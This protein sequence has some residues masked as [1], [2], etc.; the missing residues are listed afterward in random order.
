MCLYSLEWYARQ[1]C[2]V[3]TVSATILKYISFDRH[4]KEKNVSPTFVVYICN[5]V[6][7]WNML[8]V[9]KTFFKGV[10]IDVCPGTELL[11]HHH[12]Q[13]VFFFFFYFELPHLSLIYLR[14]TSLKMI[15]ESVEILLNYEKMQHQ[16]HRAFWKVIYKVRSL[17][18]NFFKANKFFFHKCKLCIV[19]K[20]FVAK[21]MSILQKYL[22][23]DYSKW[24]QIRM[25]QTW[26]EV[27]HKIFGG[28]PCEIYRR[29]C[30]MSREA[31]FSPKML[32]S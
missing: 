23:W 30:N 12:F 27:C 5:E 14:C 25:L 16:L 1:N 29:N 24:W 9:D 3:T 18:K 8:K 10:L 28:K 11:H 6:W 21:I 22:F 26:T 15:N 2:P 19:W 17:D 7:R 32:M 31:C 20:R 13:K 4:K